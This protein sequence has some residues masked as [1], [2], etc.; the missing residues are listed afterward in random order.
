MTLG[1]SFLRTG[2]APPLTCNP[3]RI[4]SNFT[5]LRQGPSCKFPADGPI[6]LFAQGFGIRALSRQRLKYDRRCRAGPLHTIV[7]MRV[8]PRNHG[9][10]SLDPQLPMK[11]TQ[12]RVFLLA[13]LL[14]ALPVMLSSYPPMVDVPQ[15]A[16]QVAALKSLLGASAWAFSDMFE[17]R[18]FTP[19]WLG[20]GM[21]MMFS[22][23]FG[24]VMA[25][26][27]V[28]AGSQCLFVWA[29]ARFSLQMKMPVEWRWLFLMLP[30]GFAYQWGFLNFIV[31]APF[32]FLFLSQVLTLR[33]TNARNSWLKI[34]LWAHFL[35]FAH[36]LIAAFFCAIAIFLLASP[37]KGIRV[38][39]Y[40]CLP[41]FSVLP[42]TIVWLVAGFQS[43]PEARGSIIWLIGINRLT[44]FF[45][46]LVSAPAPLVG[47]LLGLICIVVPFVCGARPTRSVL[48]WVPFGLYV[49]WMLLVP[50]VLG[51]NF[52]TYQ[53]FGLFG[54]P[55]Y[56]L[57]F[58][59][60]QK[61]ERLHHVRLIGVGLAL[62]SVL[63]VGWH[64]IRTTIFNSETSGYR[65][66]MQHADPGTRILMLAFD[67][68][69]QASSAPLHLHFA[70]WF[71]AE[72]GGLAEFNFARFW[73]VPVK[74]KNDAPSEIYS[75]FE[76]YP[77]AI[78]W[79]RHRGD[80]Y[81]YILIRH[82]LD[83]SNWLQEKSE[84]TVKLI[85]KSGEWQLY[86]K[87]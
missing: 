44:E 3:H 79:T 59:K 56:F 38:W 51:G 69:S 21:V 64:S 78:N 16:A 61:E 52:F 80:L 55:L 60:P 68:T 50:H 25:M 46:S 82:P 26:K 84:N 17:L 47:Q 65:Y 76:W 29:A 2:L 45:P 7:C 8:D 6:Y 71:Q 49:F 54:L 58:E 30:F 28:I 9:V 12:D 34:V 77:G 13:C 43:A 62:V 40:R 83:A 31:A 19:Y 11:N 66:V 24:M 10:T 81:D 36:F 32:G 5:G 57:C 27:L 75:G 86:G 39:L 63:V 1:D 73:G 22:I 74:Y 35:F 70:G 72:H 15:H 48:A 53:R 23:P 87:K 41:I 85:A 33:E 18:L 37:W 42:I 20:Y 67:P 14:C 4:S